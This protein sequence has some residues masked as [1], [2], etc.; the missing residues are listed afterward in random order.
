M[1]SNWLQIRNGH[2]KVQTIHINLTK[3]KCPEIS[4]ESDGWLTRE[5]RWWTDRRGKIDRQT[6]VSYELQW[7]RAGK[8]F[9]NLWGGRPNKN[10]NTLMKNV[11]IGVTW[12]IIWTD[13]ITAV[14]WRSKVHKSLHIFSYKI[15]F[16]LQIHRVCVFV[17]VCIYKLYKKNGSCWMLPTFFSL[18]CPPNSLMNSIS[19]DILTALWTMSLPLCPN[20]SQGPHVLTALCLNQCAILASNHSKGGELYVFFSSV[21][22]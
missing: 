12:S 5:K 17:C 1:S 21:F 8:G 7:L 16:S 13:L 14:Q 4:P 6:L 19:S 10:F 22:T 9:G 15:L 3:G 2:S 20:P 11:P 18:L